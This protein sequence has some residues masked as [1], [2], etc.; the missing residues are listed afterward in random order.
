MQEPPETWVRSLDW[1]DPWRREWKPTPVFWPG[2]SHEQRSLAG[3]SLWDCKESDMTE[4]LTFIFT[5]EQMDWW[6]GMQR[7][8]SKR[9]VHGVGH[10]VLLAHPA[11]KGYSENEKRIALKLCLCSPQIHASLKWLL[12]P[13]FQVFLKVHNSKPHQD[14]KT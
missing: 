9:A 13:E 7:D 6:P 5:L 2:E 3:Y 8:W 14:R 11:A 1:E 12:M 4:W 10:I